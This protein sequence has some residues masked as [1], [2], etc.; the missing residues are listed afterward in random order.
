MRLVQAFVCAIAIALVVP[1]VHG[2]AFQMDPDR[3]VPGGGIS[4][5]GWN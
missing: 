2:V 4:A 1:A 3:V 5:A